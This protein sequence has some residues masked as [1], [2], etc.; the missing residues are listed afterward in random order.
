MYWYQFEGIVSQKKCFP[1]FRYEHNKRLFQK[2]TSKF[3]IISEYGKM[4]IY[5]S[6]FKY[7]SV[8]N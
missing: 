8:L 1:S 4:Q 6:V 5:L 2:N 7:S 3:F